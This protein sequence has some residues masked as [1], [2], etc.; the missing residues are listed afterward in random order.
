MPIWSDILAEIAKTERPNGTR[1]FDRVRRK[2]L[3]EMHDRSGRNVILYASG[4]LQK[5]EV[6][7]ARV[8]IADDDVQG[9]MEAMDELDGDSLDLIVHSPGGSPETAEAIVGYVRSRFAR[10]RVIV[11][12]LAMSAATMIA[13][14]ADEI[15]LGDHSSL[16]PIDPQ[17]VLPTALG[18]RAV[19]AQSI[20]E[21]VEQAIQDSENPAK[22][23]A[24]IPMLDQYGPDLLVQCKAAVNMSKGL[25]ETWLRDYMFKGEEN[26]SRKAKSISAWLADHGNFGS[27]SRHISRS[28]LRRKGL[29][30]A[31]LEDDH[32]LRK[33]ALSAYHATT[34]AFSGTPVVKIIENHKGEAFIQSYIPAA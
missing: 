14:A 21:Q 7:P 13:C 31:R 29:F 11:P 33:S 9:L 6:P 12:H 16:G 20:L 25:V 1:D 2:Y 34:H 28:E 18:V 8:S 30:V 22:I 23:P 26:G 15:V 3:A 5:P 27:H 10:L 32:E 19:P 4:W 17:F 24:W